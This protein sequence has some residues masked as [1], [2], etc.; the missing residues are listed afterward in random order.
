M[1]LRIEALRRELVRGDAPG[2][3]MTRFF[4]AL[5]ADPRLLAAAAPATPP[6]ELE[7]HLR[8][9]GREV[10]GRPVELTA[11]HWQHLPA[12]RLW[13]GGGVL[14]GKPVTVVWCEEL[15]LGLLGLALDLRGQ[16]HFARFQLQ[17]ALAVAAG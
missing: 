3:L 17:T 7:E 16:M 15:G 12:L 13:H 11:A 6:P 10:L 8:R 1:S 4:D 5:D 2:P 9:T 14:S